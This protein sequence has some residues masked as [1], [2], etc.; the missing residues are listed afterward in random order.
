MFDIVSQI[1]NQMS[2]V[3]LQNAVKYKIRLCTLN[4][5]L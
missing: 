4:A 1:L 3:R 2:R 5:N